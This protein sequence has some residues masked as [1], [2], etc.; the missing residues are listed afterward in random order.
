M[1]RERGLEPP[2]PKGLPP[3]GSASTNSATRARGAQNGRGDDHGKSVLWIAFWQ[4]YPVLVMQLGW[5]ESYLMPEKDHNEVGLEVRQ[6]WEK[7]YEN[8]EKKQ[9]DYAMELFSMA[10]E[11]EPSF[12]ECRMALRAAQV[13]KHEKAGKLAKIASAAG[14][15]PNMAQAKLALNKKNYFG[16]IASAEKVLCAD[17]ENS[18]GHRVIVEASQALDFPH[19][20]ISSLQMLKK[21]NP[22]NKS[23]TTELA[24]ALEKLGD[25]DQAEEVMGQLAA[26]NPDDPL[27][28]QAYKDTAAKA[29]I[30]RGN[31]ERMMKE[32]GAGEEPDGGN[33]ILTIEEAMEEK[34]YVME[35]RLQSEPDN[36]KLGVD[37]AKLCV[38]QKDFERAFEYYEWVQEN[39][40]V[41]DSAIDRAIADA[42]EARFDYDIER[43]LEGSPERTVIEQDS[44]KFM[45]ENCR[46]RTEKYPTMLEFQLELGERLLKLGEV[47][48]AIQAFQRS[49]N[50]PKLKL[51]SLN[52]LGQCFMQRGMHDMALSQFEKALTEK[53]VFDE[54]KKELVY[55]L[56]NVC[57]EL[58]RH[59]DAAAHFKSIYEVDIGFLD[60]AEKVEG[61][62]SAGG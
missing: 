22:E 53:G 39:N 25:W 56:A 52:Y 58:G 48:E 16:A 4:D 50:T 45:L 27:L 15:T 61:G 2:P 8:L 5:F 57:A 24:S 42:Y 47:G 11:K 21:A 29:T 51:E 54:Q 36:Y 6:L 33:D 55:N 30:F 34:I 46:Q 10:L 35:E 59:E 1:V 62:Y 17:P 23:L 28:Q 41:G 44:D 19:T 38:E 60:V 13:K 43:C 49:Q 32:P 7:G 26:V 18:V 37:I 31:Y 20:V 12:F 3:Q 40:Q 9:Y 14:A